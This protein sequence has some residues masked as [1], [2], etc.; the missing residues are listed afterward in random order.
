MLPLHYFYLE[1]DPDLSK[2][3][4]S[5]VIE[6]DVGIYSVHVQ[7]NWQSQKMRKILCRK[8][9]ILGINGSRVKLMNRSAGGPGR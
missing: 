8:K 7:K 6:M 3:H 1:E 5:I 9:V 2:V 4:G